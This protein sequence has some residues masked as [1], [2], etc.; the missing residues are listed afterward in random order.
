MMGV[1]YFDVVY[2]T[3]EDGLVV[4][5]KCDG[6]M[7]T[8][9]RLFMLLAAREA[10]SNCEGL[11]QLWPLFGLR[12]GF[13]DAFRRKS[14]ILDEEIGLWHSWRPPSPFLSYGRWNFGFS[15]PRNSAVEGRSRVAISDLVAF[16]FSWTSLGLRFP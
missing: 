10:S 8:R 11:S 1:S 6:T 15:F 7:T 3:V 9:L 5:W 4:L 2:A 13:E 12:V 14:Q 16:F